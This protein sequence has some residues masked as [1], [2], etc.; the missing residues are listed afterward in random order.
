MTKTRILIFVP[1]YLPGFKAGGILRTL[2]NTIQWLG[3]DFAFYIVTSD[4]DLGDHSPYPSINVNE[5]Q[6]LE[7][8]KVLY[9][10]PEKITFTHIVKIINNTP[11]D[12]IYLNSFFDKKFT[13]K[14]LIAK[15]LGFI[16]GKHLILAPRGE[17][18]EGI[19]RFKYLKKILYIKVSKWLHFY[20]NIIWHASSNYE[21]MD[22]VNILNLSQKEIRVALD[23]PIK[24]QV[25]VA[26]H[27]FLE[28]P[29]RIVF[30]SRLTREKNL[31]YAIDIL[32]YVK[33]SILF[34]IYGPN[35]DSKYWNECC[36]KIQKLPKNIKVSYL[37]AVHP[38][39][40]S[41]IF[42]RYDLF[43][44]PTRGEN[45][46]HVIA[47]AVS[48]GT[49]VLV[50]KHTPWLNLEEKGIG[51]DIHLDDLHLFVSIIEQVANE[52]IDI[53]FKK[54]AL[55]KLNA[56]NILLN[57]NVLVQNKSLFQKLPTS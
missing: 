5:W 15:K 33:A 24:N 56:R 29:S 42:S 6:E 53:R 52:S 14:V 36:K 7:G 46:G 48:V 12:I 35:E 18:A 55:A 10:G 37:G 51:W 39:Q 44:F 34:D 54:R 25:H 16:Q 9:L 41:D 8:A 28:G 57:S 20:R 49:R 17:L 50:S 45:Y 40:V 2:A 26:E 19:L 13:I 27:F 43:I 1:N 31:D 23:L 3:D 22:F 38:N 32:S 21:M 11:H 4:R 30:L 47:E